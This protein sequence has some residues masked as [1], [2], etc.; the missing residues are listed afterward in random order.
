MRF[1]ESITIE[2]LHR[3]R[4]KTLD[5][6]DVFIIGK[7]GIAKVFLQSLLKLP[8]E[9]VFTEVETAYKE[10]FSE[11]DIPKNSKEFWAF[12]EKEYLYLEKEPKSVFIKLSL[13]VA[14]DLQKIAKNLKYISSERKIIEEKKMEY[15]RLSANERYYRNQLDYF[16]NK[17]IVARNE[18]V[19]FMATDIKSYAIKKSAPKSSFSFSFGFMFKESLYR[20]GR[21]SFLHSYDSYDVRSLDEYS[22]KFLDLPFLSYK[23]IIEECKK[24]PKNFKDFAYQYIVGIPDNLPSVNEKLEKLVRESHILARRKQVISTMLRHFEA[25]DYISF[26]SI[27]PLQIEGIFADI[28]REIGVSEN[29]LDISSLND[30]LHH[31]N[32][33]INSFFYFEYYSFKFPVLRNLVAHG[34]LVDGELEDTAVHL[35]LDLLPVCKLTVSEELPINYA[36]TVLDEASQ[37]NYEKLIE[38]L[39][40]RANVLIPDF[41]NVK[42]KISATE[43]LYDSADFWEYLEE[44]L[45]KLNSVD[46]IK[47]SMPLKIAGIVKKNDLAVENAEKFLKSAYNTASEAIKKRNENLEKFKKALNLPK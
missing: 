11:D 12:I 33:K 46:Q 19:D 14:D 5:E 39:D 3:L 20:F 42:E 17:N 45:N 2:E 1:N 35:M 6:N 7:K 18:I 44:Q 13:Q 30:K 10:S 23:K 8:L 22:N 21:T 25:K 26:V 40:L 47:K 15:G 37:S 28:C 31:I 34:G 38:W 32:G 29:Q 4:I 24:S 27:A 36:L 16:E 43:T 41:Y 9:T